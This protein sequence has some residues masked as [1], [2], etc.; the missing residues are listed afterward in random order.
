MGVSD[1]KKYYSLFPKM[2]GTY[3]ILVYK[4]DSS[5]YSFFPFS[6]T[7]FFS[8]S[9]FS[10]EVSTISRSQRK[11]MNI[12]LPKKRKIW[13]EQTLKMKVRKENLRKND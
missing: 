13:E 1:D 6:K 9:L 4:N 7:S 12:F 5:R 11:F 10:E 2:K 3:C 8:N